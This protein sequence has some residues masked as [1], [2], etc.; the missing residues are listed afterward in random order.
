MIIVNQFYLVHD[1]Q[2][3][4]AKG[5]PHTGEVSSKNTI[6]S[7]NNQQESQA[8]IAELNLEDLQESE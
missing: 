8:R 2:K 1:G 5:G 6:E 4:I 3:V 7:F